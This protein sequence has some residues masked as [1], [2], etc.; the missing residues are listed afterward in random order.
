M[1]LQ[2]TNGTKYQGG[3]GKFRVW[4]Q[5]TVAIIVFYTGICAHHSLY[6]CSFYE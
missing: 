5:A 6:G 3:V 1:R 2:D 4:W